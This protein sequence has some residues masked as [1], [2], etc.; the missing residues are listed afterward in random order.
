[1]RRLFDHPTDHVTVREAYDVERPRPADRPW[2][3]VCMVASI[4]G[5]TVVDSNSRGLSSKVDQEVL[6][7]LRSL[8]DVLIVGAATV[9]VEGY[10]PPRKRGQRVGVVSRRGDV[11]ATSALFTSGA[12]FLIL[13]DDAPATTI[14]AVRA[15]RGSVDLAAALSQVDAD[16]VQAEGG[17]LLNGALA[18]ADL[19]DEL[20]LT[21]SPLLAG[22]E[23][24]RVTGG[25]AQLARRMQ[26]AHV[27]ED[28][29]F[30]FTR[31]LRAS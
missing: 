16:F 15:G 10:G 4:D 25:V 22:G 27:L 6:S 2:L 9:R 1:M 24:P 31:Y 30:L 19:I 18:E 5:S 29:N 3:G 7:T 21:I 11:D 28:D 20:N 12:G 14:D 26:L 13:P 8:A 17:A 23:G